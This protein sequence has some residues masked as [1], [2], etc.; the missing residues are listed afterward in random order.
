MCA[1]SGLV[2]QAKIAWFVPHF[3]S[4]MPNTQIVKL[5]GYCLKRNWIFV[6]RCYKLRLMSL[7]ALALCH[8]NKTSPRFLIIPHPF[9]SYNT[10]PLQLHSFCFSCWAFPF[11]NLHHLLFHQC[12]WPHDQF[13]RRLNWVMNTGL[14]SKKGSM[15][16]LQ[17]RRIKISWKLPAWIMNLR[18]NVR[19]WIFYYCVNCV[20]S[21]VNNILHAPS[22]CYGTSDSV[23]RGM[24]N[25]I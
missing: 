19:A 24:N 12:F 8:V 15:N 1:A 20:A 11:Q 10:S 3:T 17:S 18:P 16:K 23:L 21:H 2:T 13:M 14:K 9:Q 4:C 6:P 7:T 22:H 25:S 5:D